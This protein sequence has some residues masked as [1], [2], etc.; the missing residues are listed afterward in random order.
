MAVIEEVTGRPVRDRC[1]TAVGCPARDRGPLPL[2]R[3]R[4]AGPLEYE[5]QAVA[6]GDDLLATLA[7]LCPANMLM[8]NGDLAAAARRI[9]K[10]H[11]WTVDHHAGQ[12]QARTHLVWANIHRHLGDAAQCLEHS[13]LSVELL[14][15]ASTPHMQVWHR[16]KLADALGLAGSMEAARQRYAQTEDLA[17]ELDQPRLLMA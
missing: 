12:L 10:I 11:Q 6:L 14:D 5:K 2:A 15:D 9:W 13:V 3:C 4:L 8:R 7:R 1:R 17:L 16:A